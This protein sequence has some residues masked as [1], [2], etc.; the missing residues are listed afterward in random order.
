MQSKVKT[1]ALPSTSQL[2][3]D[4]QQAYFYD[5]YQMTIRTDE[6][7]ALQLY[8]DLVAVCPDWIN[9]LMTLRNKVVGYFGLK[10]QNLLGDID[11]GK[12]ATSYRV[13]DR[14]GIFSLLN[15]SDN[16]VI[17]GETD[18]HLDVKLSLLKLSQNNQTSIAV[19][20]VV[21]VHNRL[22]KLYMLFVTPMHKIIVPASLSHSFKTNSFKTN[23][24]NK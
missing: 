18:K 15:I 2:H 20:T 10:N 5:S 14:V 6:K 7:S 24:F 21:H 17:L 3:D 11:K 23:S 1:I 8:L 19:S 12:L 9:Q 22:G 16:E 13:G 4:L